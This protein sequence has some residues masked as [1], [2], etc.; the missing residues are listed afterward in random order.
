[1]DKILI[2]S[3][4][5]VELGG[6][7][8]F[9]DLSF[10]LGIG[11]SLVVLGPNG[12]GKTVLLRTLLGLLPHQSGVIRWKRGARIGYVPQRMSINRD[13]PLTVAEFFGLRRSPKCPMTEALLRVGIGLADFGP[14][15]LAVLSAGQLQLVLIA[16]ALLD[17]P[18]VLLLDEPTAGIDIRGM[19]IFRSL[20]G[21][22][23]EG[24]HRSI[25]LVTHELSFAPG[26]R[27]H[28][29]HVN[30]QVPS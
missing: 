28:V 19:G 11:E 27:T 23:S 10:E 7:S 4:L 6:R 13:V 12:A 26:W 22:L 21:K 30:E 25:I 15:Q 3:G 20:L 16:W 24:E 18:D 1:M 14:R 5:R 2:V 29:I 17:E 9:T 8:I